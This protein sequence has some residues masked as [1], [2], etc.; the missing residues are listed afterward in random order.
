MDP[1]YIDIG[2]SNVHRGL[3]ISRWGDHWAHMKQEHIK[4][5][6]RKCQPLSKNAMEK[7]KKKNRHYF[8]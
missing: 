5:S 6:V 2:E 8:I 7:R 3:D 4:P 1:D